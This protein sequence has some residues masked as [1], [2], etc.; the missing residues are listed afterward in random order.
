MKVVI[1]PDAPTPLRPDQLKRPGVYQSTENTHVRLIVL[2]KGVVIELW[3]DTYH[4]PYVE[5]RWSLH[6]FA[7]VPAAQVSFV[8]GDDK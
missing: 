5:G 8:F 2:G 4:G 7:P 3:G 1:E 6:Q